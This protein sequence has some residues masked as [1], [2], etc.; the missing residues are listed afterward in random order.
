M[1]RTQHNFIENNLGPYTGGVRAMY[2]YIVVNIKKKI[3]TKV[4]I[5]LEKKLIIAAFCILISMGTEDFDKELKLD[6]EKAIYSQLSL[7]KKL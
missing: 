6:K 7:A 3:C 2:I 5:L 4:V 1:N